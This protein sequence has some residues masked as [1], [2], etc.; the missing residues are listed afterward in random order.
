MTSAM[1]PLS[2]DSSVTAGVAEAFLL[3]HIDLLAIHP[4]TT[5]MN[6]T[7]TGW[8]TRVGTVKHVL[9]TAQSEKTLQRNVNPIVQ[10]TCWGWML[11]EEPLL[12][13]FVLVACVELSELIQV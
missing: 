10:P 11:R 4:A 3:A 7:R 6:V 8:C 9:E 12:E 13:E 1:R 2:S 5:R